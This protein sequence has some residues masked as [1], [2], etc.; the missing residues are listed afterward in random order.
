MDERWR[1]IDLSDLLHDADNHRRACIQV[2][3]EGSQ[4]TRTLLKVMQ[5]LE[6]FGVHADVKQ[7]INDALFNK[8]PG[9]GLQSLDADDQLLLRSLMPCDLPLP[10]CLGVASIEQ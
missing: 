9:G 10:V 6:D 2:L 3:E 5:T 8:R 4:D 7:R 1:L